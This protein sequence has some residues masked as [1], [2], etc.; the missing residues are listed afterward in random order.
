MNAVALADSIVAGNTAVV[1]NDN[2][3]GGFAGS[4]NITSGDPMLHI[5][6][7]FGGPTMTMPPMAGSPA[8]NASSASAPPIDQRGAPRPQGQGFDAGA[9]EVADAGYQPTALEITF[10]SVDFDTNTVVLRWK[11]FWGSYDVGSS[12]NFDFSE[13]G[14]AAIPVTA[15]NGIVDTTSWPGEIQF[16]FHDPAAAGSRHFWRVG[17]N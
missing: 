5:L 16:V 8:I 4:G 2:I 12:E 15:D 13:P 11:G 6:G 17:A 3:R 14:D 9:V 10:L 7:D 1:A